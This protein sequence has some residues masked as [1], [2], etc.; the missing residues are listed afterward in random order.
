MRRKLMLLAVLAAVF[1]LAVA[2]CGGD[3]EAAP[4][5]AG[6]GRARSRRARSRRARSRRARSRRARSAR[7]PLPP[8]RNPYGATLTDGD[9][10]E[11]YNPDP[12]ILQQALGGP[13]ALPSEEMP[14]NIILAGLAR[15]SVAVD[16]DKALECWTNNKCDTGSGGELIACYADGFGGNTA[17]QLFKMEFILQALTYPEIGEILYTDS[18]L[19]TQKAISDHRSMISQGC[20][21]MLSYPDAGDALLPVYR[22]ATGRDIPIAL[23]AGA[24]IGEQGVDYMTATGRNFCELGKGYAAIM[25]ENLPDGGEIAFLSGTPGNTTSPQWQKCEKEALNPNIEVVATADT[26]WSRQGALEAASSILAAHPNL[27]GWSYEFA[28]AFVGVMRAYDAAQL[29]VDTIATVMTD[30]NSLF[31]AW[32]DENNPNFKLWAGSASSYEARFGLTAGMMQRAGA[33]VPPQ[34]N[35]LVGLTPVDANSCRADLSLESAPSA[36]VSPELQA[37]MFAK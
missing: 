20:D 29:P 24:N 12:A 34:I 4:G 25:N 15:A 13:S 36:T 14:R 21:V 11:T 35:N 7:S 22:E 32:K 33:D 6:A 31:C 30:E 9:F 27:K 19:D 3:D 23:W 16:E 2:A 8:R 1:G 5:G 37:K 10:G 17:R 26:S 28:D 18:N